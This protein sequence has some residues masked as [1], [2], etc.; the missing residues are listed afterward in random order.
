M[1][2]PVGFE[3]R[4]SN[5]GA[6]AIATDPG[7]GLREPSG[8]I[9]HTNMVRPAVSSGANSEL[10]LD[11]EIRSEV[12]FEGIVGQSVALREVF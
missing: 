10:Y 2:L 1:N 4:K 7:W 5:M 6:T 12:E 3:R 11:E 9:T 8:V